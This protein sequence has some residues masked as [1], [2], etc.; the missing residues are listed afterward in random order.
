MDLRAKAKQDE[1]RRHSFPDHVDPDFL[2]RAIRKAQE[3]LKGPKPPKPF[4]PSLDQLRLAHVAKDEAIEE[5]LRPK[6]KPLPTSLPPKDEAEV[7]TLFC[8]RGVISKCGREQVSHEDISRLRPCQWLNDEIINFYGQLI[9]MRAEGSKENP[10]AAS[11]GGRG[12]PLNAHYFNTFFWAKLKGQGY[13]GGRLSKWTKKAS[14]C[15]SSSC[16]FGP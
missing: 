15:G 10:G 9:Q 1:F 11:G 6:R 7:D 5:R 13:K 14:L 8:K 3:A 2:Q 4:V 16:K 12:K